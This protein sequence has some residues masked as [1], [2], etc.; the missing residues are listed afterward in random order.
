MTPPNGAVEDGVAAVAVAAGKD[1][2]TALIVFGCV[3]GFVALLAFA[4]FLIARPDSPSRPQTI[5]ADELATAVGAAF[6]KALV[7]RDAR[8]SPASDPQIAALRADIAALRSDLVA[9]ARRTDEI[10]ALLAKPK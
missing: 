8:V 7:E 10:L 3:I 4:Y 1:S 6:S 9:Q 5:Q 2:K